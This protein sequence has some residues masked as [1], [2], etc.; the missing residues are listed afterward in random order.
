M[1]T[2]K[3]VLHNISR[4]KQKKISRLLHADGNLRN[5][6]NSLKKQ[7]PLDEFSSII[8]STFKRNTVYFSALVGN[9]FPDV[10]SK[11]SKN[12]RLIYLNPIAEIYWSSAILSL[13]IE[14]L[15][16]FVTQKSKFENNYIF[17]EYEAALETLN[18]IEE[19][20]GT[21]IWLLENKIQLL[22]LKNGV[23]EQKDF[24]ET[25]ISQKGIDS[26]V[27]YLGY[28]FSYRSENNVS[29]KT[30]EEYMFD[31]KKENSLPKELIDY[32]RY[33]I[34]PYDLTQI[35]FES[36][37]INFSDLS[38]VVDKYHC[39]ISMSLLYLIKQEDSPTN[40]TLYAL[41]NLQSINDPTIDRILEIFGRKAK[42]PEKILNT[43]EVFDLYTEGNYKNVI[44][45]LDQ[46][47]TNNPAS[48]HFYEVYVRA[49][50]YIE[51]KD[52]PFPKHSL[53]YKILSGI[54]SVLHLS[55][56]YTNAVS[57]LIKT[58]LSCPHQDI[59][60][61]ISA[62]ISRTHTFVQV[63][64]FSELDLYWAMSSN[65]CNPWHVDI[66]SDFLNTKVVFDDLMKVS[67]QSKALKL[68]SFLGLDF[69]EG[70]RS[71]ESLNLPI[72]R[73]NMYLGH[74]AF[75]NKNYDEAICYYSSC[76]NIT[77]VINNLEASRYLYKSLFENKKYQDCIELI[78]DAYIKNNQ[79]YTIFETEKLI[80]VITNYENQLEDCGLTLPITLQILA[81]HVDSKLETHISSALEDFLSQEELVSPSKINDLIETYP[82]NR[83]IYFLHHVCTVRTMEDALL[84]ETYEE[85]QSE[86]IAICQILMELDRRNSD[87]YSQEIKTL[88]HDAEVSVSMAIV[89]ESKVYVD[90]DGVKQIA[91]SFLKDQ[92]ERYLLL[93]EIP[94][95][96][97]QASSITKKMEKVLLKD[98][99]S[100]DQKILSIPSTEKESLFADMYS[101][102]LRI[103]VYSPEY[104]L[105]AHVGT[106]IRHGKLLGQL[107]SAIAVKEL[108]TAKIQD[109]DNYQKNQYWKQ[110]LS[111]ITEKDFEI[112]DK[113]LARFSKKVDS[114]LNE[115]NYGW[116]AIKSETT[117]QGIFDF[118]A[119]QVGQITL[120][121]SIF[122]S[123]SYEEFV[124]ILVEDYWVN[125]ER[126]MSSLRDKLNGSFL[127]QIHQAFNTLSTNLE[128]LPQRDKLSLL[129]DSVAEARADFQVALEAVVSW[130][131]RPKII[132]GTTFSLALAIS[133]ALKQIQKCYAKHPINLK[134]KI[135]LD[136]QFR[137]ESLRS[138]V[139]IFFVLFQNAI[140]HSKI[141]D[142]IVSISLEAK[143]DD[144]DLIISV[145]N[146]IALITDIQ[147]LTENL[148]QAEINYA[149]DTAMLKARLEKGSGLSK[150]WRI[151]QYSLKTEHSIQ[152]NLIDH[153]TVRVTL[154]LND[155]NLK[156]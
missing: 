84:F 148:K 94:N 70:K 124:D 141:Q 107:R 18:K 149:H 136:Y 59:S 1:T 98:K 63:E 39:F 108:L 40:P 29:L 35:E 153:K 15:S 8:N 78:C 22:Q 89:D 151:S 52:F 23:K 81:K 16:Q 67:P 48:P 44:E 118:E 102:L 58:A 10:Y 37:V 103:F 117:T 139:E 60:L 80:E 100:S 27:A 134:S 28:M 42:N 86:R 121:E 105:D 144:G 51:F 152:L 145:E 38:T 133:V 3:P 69:E 62:F 91:G 2:E 155:S 64:K 14:K 49:A 104:G 36:H 24:L 119:D 114:L 156:A 5:G 9:P 71:I 26:W 130:F 95:L 106:Q 32:I 68:R 115:V 142:D 4:E 154:H 132:L 113:H 33:Q 85:I 129:M 110:K 45:I 83:V 146:G 127:N 76:K 88:I 43:L 128:S 131:K 46:V 116:V 61:Q 125:T 90:I 150:I 143:A 123:T 72:D 41:E 19:D 126:C 122:P 65:Y 31:L 75:H 47:L 7:F 55:E 109:S 137:P 54:R 30:L 13:F 140:I 77:N 34:I 17:G 56:N 12:K 111:D 20:F 82:L 138:L 97:Y 53:L 11:I 73:T 96:T 93:L 79:S 87:I 6:I 101:E 112:I 50:E 21:S 57:E 92:Y 99:A 66:F 147:S 25:I 135:D 74:L 120:M